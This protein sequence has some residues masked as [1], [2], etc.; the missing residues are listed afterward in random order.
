M[1]YIVI[2]FFTDLQDNDFP[3]S[4][5]DTYPRKEGTSTAERI[6]ELAGSNNKQGQPLIMAVEE[7]TEAKKPARKTASKRAKK[8][9]AE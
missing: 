3:Y 9:A 8:T 5:G 2:R 4:V 1:K 7:A 6:A